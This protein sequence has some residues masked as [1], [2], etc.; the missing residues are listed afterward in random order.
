[1]R[2]LRWVKK[3]KKSEK[4]T[5]TVL[6]NL[7]VKSTQLFGHFNNKPIQSAQNLNTYLQ[8]FSIFKHQSYFEVGI[9]INIVTS[10]FRH[11]SLITKI[12]TSSL[13]YG[14]E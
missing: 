10:A 12:H 13:T 2:L 8:E 11:L 14:E 3:I 4:T 1:M 9:T 7:R 5:S 6:W